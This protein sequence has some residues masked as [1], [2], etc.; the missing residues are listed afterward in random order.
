MD[1]AELR[2]TLDAPSTP[3][4]KKRMSA[5]ALLMITNFSRVGEI[6][7]M[8]TEEL[9]A[10]K[11]VD[12]GFFCIEVIQKLFSVSLVF[13]SKAAVTPEI[14]YLNCIKCYPKC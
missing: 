14:G 10:A 2:R 7:N 9:Y 1:L 4:Y 11:E 13:S 12:P 6:A 5:V 8:T 3:K